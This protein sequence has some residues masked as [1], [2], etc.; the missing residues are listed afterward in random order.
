MFL[1]IYFVFL[2]VLDLDKGFLY[3][4]N[5]GYWFSFCKLGL[6]FIDKIFYNELFIVKV[7]KFGY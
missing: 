4:R 7:L 6:F 3:N 2:F 5:N 1:K